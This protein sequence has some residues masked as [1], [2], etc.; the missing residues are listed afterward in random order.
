MNYFEIKK[1]SLEADDRK[2]WIWAWNGDFYLILKTQ[3]RRKRVE[4]IHFVF[5]VIFFQFIFTC[6]FQKFFEK[7]NTMY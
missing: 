6:V 2:W 3:F 5:C 7:F 4:N 1:F